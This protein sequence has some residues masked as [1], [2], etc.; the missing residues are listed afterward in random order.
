M[1]AD[2]NLKKI[3]VKIIIF[4]TI[5]NMVG[6]A[7]I[8]LYFRFLNLTT[9]T[10]DFSG[11]D[12]SQYSFI[13]DII[14]TSIYFLIAF[15][16]AG[17]KLYRINEYF[18]KY[19]KNILSKDNMRA[20]K[21]EILNLPSFAIRVMVMIWFFVSSTITFSM[22]LKGLSGLNIFYF[23]FV[24]F[25]IGG[26]LAI[27]ISYYL[28]D[29]FLRKTIPEVFPDGDFSDVDRV[30]NFHINSRMLIAF[31][32]GGILPVFMLIVFSSNFIEL[33]KSGL[34]QPGDSMKYTWSI[35]FISFLS[36]FMT[37]V[38][39]LYFSRNIGNELIA[40][41]KGMKKVENGD[42]NVS[43]IVNNKD[44]IGDVNS[45]FNKMVDGLKERDK[46]K[47]VFGKYVSSNVRDKILS[48][49]IKLGGEKSIASILFCDIRNF[50]S[51]SEKL[52]AEDVVN[53]LNSYFNEM[54]KPV[55][56]NNGILDKFIG[57]A[58][59]A[60]FGA[61][62]KTDNHAQDAVEAA[63]TMRSN[64]SYFNELR[65]QFNREKVKIGIGINSGEIIA[66]NIGG[67]E[68]MEYTVIGDSVNSASR[69]EGLSKVYGVDIII[70]ENTLNLL[71]DR[72]LYELRELDLVKV[73]GR[74]EPLKIYEVL[75]KSG[76]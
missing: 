27:V 2:F 17:V 46:I 39:S 55:F 8:M 51:F 76:S 31:W 6:A 24:L 19:S 54:I 68:R 32:I 36:L 13:P 59:M 75:G 63:L 12:V 9:I 7:F 71:P 21:R 58:I 73:K 53:F 26:S 67:S 20:F 15:V 4:V 43:L 23:F 25:I 70:T 5:P 1:K 62:V 40:L 48:D 74:E 56:H 64:L 41:G 69:V 22:Y 14:I 45:G 35:I 44:E 47:D 50:T 65:E 37:V 29:S 72:S 30:R 52:S 42:F 66:G 3:Y 34:S 28:F 10:K 33:L 61:P 11:G 49:D 38:S 18:N 16:I 60:V 57:D